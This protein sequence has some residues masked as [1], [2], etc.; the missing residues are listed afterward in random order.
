MSSEGIP[1]R[2]VQEAELTPEQIEVALEQESTKLEGNVEVLSANAEKIGMLSDEQMD[3]IINF[4]ERNFF[5]NVGALSMIMSGAA[6]KAAEAIGEGNVNWAVV[7]AGIGLG[8][9]VGK[10]LDEALSGVTSLLISKIKIRAIE[11]NKS[12]PE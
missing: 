1:G 7:A 3:K 8:A 10:M 5:A 2:S 11:T 9:A 6:Y 12:Q 4:L